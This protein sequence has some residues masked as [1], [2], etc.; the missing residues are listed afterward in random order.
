VSAAPTNSSPQCNPPSGAGRRPTA[1]Q[2]R[3]ELARRRGEPAAKAAGREQAIAD[4][5]FRLTR[6]Q[7]REIAEGAEGA[8]GA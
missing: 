4:G 3:R 8:E 6:G 7:L 2:A 1:E 5:T